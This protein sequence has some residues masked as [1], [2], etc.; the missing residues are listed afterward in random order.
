MRSVSS[1]CY[2]YPSLND[3]I[4]LSNSVLVVTPPIDTDDANNQLIIRDQVN[5]IIEIAPIVPKLHKLRTLLR[6]RE[7]SESDESM[8]SEDDPSV[9]AFCSADY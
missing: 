4:V 7:Y 9:S 5:E 1:L 6:G 8:D 3:Q 2:S